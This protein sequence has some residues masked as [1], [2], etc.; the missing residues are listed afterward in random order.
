M[1][2]AIDRGCDRERTCMTSRCHG[3][4]PGCVSSRTSLAAV[5]LL[6]MT[7]VAGCGRELS[8]T[9]DLGECDDDRLSL[10]QV[11][12]FRPKAQG[13]PFLCRLSGP[14]SHRASFWTRARWSGAR[15]RARP[16]A[17]LRSDAG[18]SA[19][20]NVFAWAAEIT[21]SQMARLI[22]SSS[23]GRPPAVPCRLATIARAAR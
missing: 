11:W 4:A 8:L 1:S 17:W 21:R 18:V 14:E 3:R 13:S 5:L 10:V 22:S 6:L 16:C 19:L 2:P 12:L 7:L 23:H 15:P 20:A 9:L